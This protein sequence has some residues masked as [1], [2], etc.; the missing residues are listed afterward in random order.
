MIGLGLDGYDPDIGK[1]DKHPGI[2]AL[3]YTGLGHL[4]E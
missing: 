4:L 3:N 1:S 2:S